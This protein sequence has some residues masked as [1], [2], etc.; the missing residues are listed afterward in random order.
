MGI[1]LASII[2]EWNSS[3]ATHRPRNIEDDAPVAAG[4]AQHQVTHPASTEVGFPG[5][6]ASLR[7]LVG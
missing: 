3:E 6:P 7:V 2:D 4:A 1:R 5:T